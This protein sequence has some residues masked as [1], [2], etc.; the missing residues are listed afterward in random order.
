[1]KRLLS[2]GDRYLRRCNWKDIGVIKA[3]VFSVGVFAGTFIPKK[4][5]E[6]ARMIAWIGFVSTAVPIMTKFFEVAADKSE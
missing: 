6:C 3:C 5:T 4:K 1:M 2:Y